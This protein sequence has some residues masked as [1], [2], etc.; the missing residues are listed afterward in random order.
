MP[1]GKDDGTAE[2]AIPVTPEMWHDLHQHGEDPVWK[3]HEKG[4]DRLRMKYLVDEEEVQII[5][6][7]P[8]Y[9]E[10]CRVEYW[11]T[12]RRFDKKRDLP[13]R[14]VLTYTRPGTRDEKMRLA[15]EE[16]E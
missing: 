3:L 8:V 1:W 4:L 11:R 10:S 9:C 15:E 12:M 13:R 7:D 2:V 5:G 14:I 6:S 16:E